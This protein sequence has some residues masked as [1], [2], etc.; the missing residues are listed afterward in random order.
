MLGIRLASTFEGEASTALQF[1]AERYTGGGTLELPALCRAQDGRI[2]LATDALVG[3]LLQ[4]RLA[5]GDPEELA[6]LFH[7]GLARQIAEACVLGREQTGVSTVALSGGVFQNTLLLRLI[8]EKLREQGFQVL[9]HHLIPPND[10]GIA[11]GQA[12][13]A[14]QKINE[15]N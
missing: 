5:G 9:T 12:V 1:A 8:A 6:Y 3:E 11:L 2:C 7:E 14:M 10:G 13:Y 4:R 15:T